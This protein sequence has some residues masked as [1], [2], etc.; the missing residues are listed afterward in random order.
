MTHISRSFIKLLLGIIIFVGIP[1][2]SWGMNDFTGFISHPTRAIYCCFTFLFQIYLVFNFPQIGNNRG[3][4][5]TVN[6][7][8]HS[9]IYLLQIIPLLILV[10]APFSDSNNILTLKIDNLRYPGLLFFIIG[11]ILMNWAEIVL[12]KQFS[13]EVTIQNNHKLIS[14][15]PFRHLRHPRY[16]GI[17]LFNFGIALLFLSIIALVLAF[18]LTLVLLWRINDEEKLLHEHFGSEWISYKEK[19]WCLI[20]YIY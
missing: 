9:I 6:K 17:I 7:R 10:S 14:H 1:L 5:N 2:V 12:D 3:E 19:T 15:G 8:Q 11:F 16:L 13:V 18:L 20:P 4:G